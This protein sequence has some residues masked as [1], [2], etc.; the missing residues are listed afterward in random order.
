MP[1]TLDELHLFC[2]IVELGSLRAAGEEIGTDPSSVTRRLSSLEE[3]LGTRL[4]ARSRVRSTATEAGQRYYR[5]LKVLLEQLSAVE[6]DIGNIAA[7]PRGVLRVAAPSVFGARH[8]GPW[9]HEL[10]REAPGLAIELVLTDRALDLVEN[11][12]DL[13]VRIGVLPD[14]SLTALRLGAM[15]TVLVAAPSYLERAGIPRAPRD[16]ERHQFI[17]HAGELQGATLALTGPG[18]RNLRLLCKSQFTVS[19]I[20]GVSEAVLAGAGVNAG[21]R[22]LYAD[23]IKRGELVH[24]LPAWSPPTFPI[25]A[26]TLPGRY[27][28]AKI[29]A[30]LEMLRARV[31]TLPGV[32]A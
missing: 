9:L 2:R 18:K 15:H 19:S 29:A 11:G 31:R 4:I 12:I 21:P 10:Q 23:P 17:L 5:E 32:A 27:R 20:L 25:H 8:V 7:V 30:A 14:S 22:W 24:V 1:T 13:A 16:L 3:R 28:P 26:L 6:E